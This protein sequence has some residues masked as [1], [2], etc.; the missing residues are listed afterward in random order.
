MRSV[1][2]CQAQ[3]CFLCEGDKGGYT[4][5]KLEDTYILIGLTCQEEDNTKKVAAAYKGETGRNGYDTGKEHLANLKKKSE[6][7]SVLWLHS[8]QQHSGRE[9][10]Q[11]IQYR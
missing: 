3:D 2:K 6:D 5:R 7:K 10:I 9:D 8:L 4:R 11:Y 1:K